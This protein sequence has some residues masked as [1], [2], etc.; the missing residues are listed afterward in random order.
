MQQGATQA[1]VAPNRDMITVTMPVSAVETALDTRIHVFGHNHHKIQIMRAST[2]YSLPLHIAND[3][4]LV[5]ELLQSPNLHSKTLQGLVGGSGDWPNACD[6][7]ACK[8]LVTPAVLAQRYKL[9][10]ASTFTVDT[11]STM[12]VSEFQGQYLGMA[13]VVAPG[14]QRTSVHGDW[15]D[16]KVIAC[17]ME[18][19]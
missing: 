10:N 3:V 9:P 5:G 8:G 7:A 15:R 14:E 1:I 6:A 11:K 17:S 18:I 13:S 2:G 12:A 4:L 16:I 19:Y